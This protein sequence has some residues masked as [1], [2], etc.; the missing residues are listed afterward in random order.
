MSLPASTVD[1]ER[2]TLKAAIRLLKSRLR[3]HIYN[4]LGRDKPWVEPLLTFEQAI[5]EDASQDWVKAL[6]L[7][8]NLQDPSTRE[9]LLNLVKTA[10]SVAE[11]ETV[12]L[13]DAPGVPGHVETH[14]STFQPDALL[15]MRGV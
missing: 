14:R 11:E 3:C 12:L 13:L 6:S 5:E 4:E 1:A 10:L 9:G 7:W 8:G 2:L 15:S